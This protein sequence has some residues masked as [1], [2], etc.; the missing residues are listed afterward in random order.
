MRKHI[1]S[2]RDEDFTI[3]SCATHLIPLEDFPIV[4]FHSQNAN[5]FNLNWLPPKLGF[6]IAV[7]P[8][9]PTLAFTVAGNQH[10]MMTNLLVEM[11]NSNMMKSKAS[12][13]KYHILRYG[14]SV[15]GKQRGAALTEIT[16][17]CIAISVLHYMNIKEKINFT[18]FVNLWSFTLF[19]PP[20]TQKRS[21]E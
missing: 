18:F 5:W 1:V 12:D 15:Q 16:W 4:K 8:E 20:E 21:L 2:I 13:A 11:L 6:E 10:W 14:W 17:H 3:S 7:A 9:F 19:L